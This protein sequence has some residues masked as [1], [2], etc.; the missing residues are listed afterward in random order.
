MRPSNHPRR[1]VEGAAALVVRYAERGLMEELSRAVETGNPTK[2]TEALS[3]KNHV[4]GKPALIGSGRARDVAVNVVLP[5]LHGSRLLAGDSVGAAEIL[6]LYRVFGLL[7][8]NE[9]TRELGRTLLDPEW[10]RV[11]NNAR[12]QQGL[13]HLQRVLAGAAIR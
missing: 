13:I 8:D 4:D 11:A 10:G 5:F 2:I 6:E 1:R 12:R 7:T 3:V 9:I